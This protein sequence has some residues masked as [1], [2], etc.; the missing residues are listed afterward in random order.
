MNE[1]YEI[2]KLLINIH[3]PKCSPINNGISSHLQSS[4]SPFGIELTSIRRNL[5]TEI[6]SNVRTMD[7]RSLCQTKSVQ[8]YEQKSV[9]MPSRTRSISPGQRTILNDDD[10][11]DDEDD[12]DSDQEE[13]IITGSDTRGLSPVRK[14]DE[15]A[16]KNVQNRSLFAEISTLIPAFISTNELK[17]IIFN[18]A[19]FLVGGE[20]KFDEQRKK[21]FEENVERILDNL[22]REQNAIWNVGNDTSCVNKE[23]LAQSKF[24]YEFV[25]IIG[26]G[27]IGMAVQVNEI[28]G[29][30]N[31]IDLLKTQKI[32][33][34]KGPLFKESTQRKTS[35]SLGVQTRGRTT[36]SSLRGATTPGVKRKDISPSNNALQ[37]QL[38]IDITDIETIEPRVLKVIVDKQAY[39]QELEI[40]AFLNG[41]VSQNQ[42]K[43]KEEKKN[44]QGLFGKILDT[45]FVETDDIRLK[46]S[47]NVMTIYNSFTCQRLPSP[48]NSN[49]WN[50]F[51]EGL[52]NLES[53]IFSKTQLEIR[54]Q[55]GGFIG[56]FVLEL[57]SL[58][59]VEIFFQT[60]QWRRLTTKLDK[61]YSLG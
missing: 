19:D 2:N 29:S 44:N 31:L 11:S 3:D 28:V 16:T 36:E 7:Q 59:N 51:V 38:E 21:R 14:N 50:L 53:K 40:L 10:D 8:S 41:L 47:P 6:E 4:P 39:D 32:T 61:V 37:R 52:Q 34:T 48:S 60:P 15:D 35:T 1:Y 30:E 12:D 23:S 55:R 49:G 24:F 25:S 20:L 5:T 9:N 42:F 45:L 33:G 46:K 58:N 56:Y 13:E 18:T 54:R 17:N 57:A 22:S 43:L 27:A 26:T